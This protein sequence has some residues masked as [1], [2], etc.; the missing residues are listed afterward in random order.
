MADATLE[1]IAAGDLEKTAE[2]YAAAH[3]NVKRRIVVC[4][5]TGCIANGSMR[6]FEKL[7]KT[8]E[9]AGMDVTIELDIHDCSK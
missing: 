9:A 2:A 5:G 3:K 8:A 1:R 4:G 7:K 6:V